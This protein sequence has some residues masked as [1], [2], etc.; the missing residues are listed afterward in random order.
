MAV[1]PAELERYSDLF[2]RSVMDRPVTPELG[3]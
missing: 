2:A 3:S 1:T